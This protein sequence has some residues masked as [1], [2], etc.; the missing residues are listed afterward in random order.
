LDGNG[1]ANYNDQSETQAPRRPPALQLFK[2]WQT[3]TLY[4]CMR[5]NRRVS[6]T[7]YSKYN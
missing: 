2:C 3:K 1:I 7:A 5:V 4:R 6:S